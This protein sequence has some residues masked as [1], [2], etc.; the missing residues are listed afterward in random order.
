MGISNSRDS[1]K[2]RCKADIMQRVIDPSLGF[3]GR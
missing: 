1:G 2:V 3:V